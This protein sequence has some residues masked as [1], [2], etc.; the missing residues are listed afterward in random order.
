MSVIAF[1]G[2]DPTADARALLNCVLRDGDI[3]GADNDGR[4]A[5]LLML[6]PLDT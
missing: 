2:R 5:L 6:D 3:V 1:R 4:T